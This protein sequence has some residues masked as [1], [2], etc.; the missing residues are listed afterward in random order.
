MF[1]NNIYENNKI[2]PNLFKKFLTPKNIY[3]YLSNYV[4]GQEEAKKRLSVSICNHFKKIKLNNLFG[5]ELDK[6]NILMI[7]PSGSGKTFLIQK[8]C[9]LINI[10]FVIVDATS[11]TEAGYVGEDVDSILQKLFHNSEC[12]VKKTEFGI[13]YIDEI[14]KI[15]KKKSE[16]SNNRDIS[17][18]GVQQALLKLI[19]GT[20]CN[21]SL[22]GNKKAVNQVFL[23]INTVN[24]LFICGG[25]FYGL[26]KI[27]SERLEKNSLGFS[28]NLIKNKM[29]Y[30][31]LMKFLEFDDLVKFGIIP[32]LIGRLPIILKLNDLDIETLK[33]IL[34]NPKNSIIEQYNAI[35]N[36]K[37]I[38]LKIDEDSL[39]IIAS[40]AYKKKT[41][42]RGLKNIIDSLLF[43]VIYEL[44]ELYTL[45]EILINKYTFNKNCDSLLLIHNDK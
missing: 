10:P 3:N 43:S 16:T 37:N 40:M 45:R 8:L 12:N 7:G 14:D 6:S 22:T 33:N 34:T 15:S 32:E 27:I 42:A 30:N 31:A 23:N 17:G 36:A 41:G 2:K 19:E 1:D 44:D 9:K 25:A 4:I 24:I 13:V 18:E 35:L 21:I 11:L 38:I 39:E 20:I 28:N 29:S 26:D 5:F